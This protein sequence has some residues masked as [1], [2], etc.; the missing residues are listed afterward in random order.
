[1]A[2]E[3]R[4]LSKIPMSVKEEVGKITELNIQVALLTAVLH[5]KSPLL[6]I[7]GPSND[8]RPSCRSI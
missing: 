6:L 7:F 3:L 1:M 5:G 4:F 2:E 8:I